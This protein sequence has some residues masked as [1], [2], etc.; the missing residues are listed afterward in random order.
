VLSSVRASED[1][2]LSLRTARKDGREVV[3]L[4]CVLRDGSHAVE[5]DVYPVGAIRVEPVSRAPY[6][7]PSEAEADAFVDEAVRALGYLGCD[8]R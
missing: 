3:S 1:Q 4:R 2:Q 7:F 5:C 8:V 6:C